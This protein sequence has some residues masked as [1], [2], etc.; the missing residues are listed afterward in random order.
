MHKQVRNENASISRFYMQPEVAK[1]TCNFRLLSVSGLGNS[2][3]IKPLLQQQL[4][5][6]MGLSGASH[7]G[8]YIHCRG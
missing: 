3:A 8:Q 5:R 2:L 7:F 1:N 4:I 6:V